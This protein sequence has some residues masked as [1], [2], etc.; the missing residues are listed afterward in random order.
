MSISSS[1]RRRSMWRRSAGDAS[2]AAGRAPT[3]STRRRWP[4]SFGRRRWR[5]SRL[6]AWACRRPV[7]GSG[8]RMASRWAA[9]DKALIHLGR[10][11]YRGVL[12]E[13]AI[14][15]CE[16][17]RVSFR[18]RNAETGKSARRT[19]SGV[20][21]LWLILQHVLAAQGLSPRAPFRL[22]ARQL[23]APD[24]LAAPLAEVRSE[25]LHARAPG[26]ASDSLRLLWRRDGDR[27]DADS[28]DI[29]RSRRGRAPH[30]SRHLTS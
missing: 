9:A 20:D 13:Q 16:N 29:V 21:F 10:Y 7:R 14:L 25:T 19:R 30:R 23:Q 11:L 15:A 12:R 6:L 2:G 3:C 27:Q 4:R 24:R 17:G 1:P 26:A 8:W 28:S 5:R 22:P 18:Y